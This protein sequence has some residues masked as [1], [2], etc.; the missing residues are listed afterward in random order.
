ML[1]GNYTL[2]EILDSNG[3]KLVTDV[4]YRAGKP[5]LPIK[6]TKSTRIKV[7]DQK[8]EFEEYAKFSD[9]MLKD[10][11]KLDPSF[12]IERSSLGDKNG[13]YYV[14]ASYTILQH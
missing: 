13:Y 8:Q 6:V 11:K 12:S 9:E 1:Y 2:T 4:N 3:S 5:N 10:S 14:V 7:V